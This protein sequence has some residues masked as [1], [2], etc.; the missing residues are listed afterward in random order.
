[1][2]R[3]D[4]GVSAFSSRGDSGEEAMG[5]AFDDC[6]SSWDSASSSRE[7]IEDAA[8]SDWSIVNTN[9]RR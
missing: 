6:G 7:W 8:D 5:T 9:E 3:D 2:P 1:M 4:L